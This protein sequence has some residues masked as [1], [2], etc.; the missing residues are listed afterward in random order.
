MRL[1]TVASNGMLCW[2]HYYQDKPDPNGWEAGSGD[3]LAQ[4]GWDKYKQITA[5]DRGVIYA[6]T[7]DGNLLWH[8]YRTGED[9]NKY[10][11]G[12]VAGSGTV[13]GQ[14]GWNG[15]KQIAAAPNGVIY[16]VTQ[17][18]NLLWYQYPFIDSDHNPAPTLWAAGSGTV[19][20]QGGWNGFKQIAAASNGVI[21]AVTPDGNLL[22]YR[23]T[24]DIP[25]ANGWADSGTVIEQGGW[26][27]FKQIA[28]ASNG[29][30]YAVTP[31]GNLL[32]YHPVPDGWAPR[33]GSVVGQGGWNMFNHITVQ[34]D[35]CP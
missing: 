4:G 19:I 29:V 17:D 10:P 15:F 22:R 24:Q 3:P 35:R 30:I 1:Y 16:A 26:A 33:S 28:A 11:D 23:Y 21:Y 27:A 13:I 34:F 6:V 25:V 9:P 5:A 2:Y 12:W 32:W 8:R 20:G 14:G 7:Q 18:G 31:D